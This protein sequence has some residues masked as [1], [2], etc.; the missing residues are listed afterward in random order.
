MTFGTGDASK[1]FKVNVGGTEHE[2]TLGAGSTTAEK[3]QP[4]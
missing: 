2:I 1:K 3:A 4:M